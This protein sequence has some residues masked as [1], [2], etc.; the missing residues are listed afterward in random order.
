MRRVLALL[1]SLFLV[2]IASTAHA[3]GMGPM[4]ATPIA[5]DLTKVPVGTWAD[6]GMKIGQMEMKARWALVSRNAKG[7]TLETI[8]EGGMMAMMGGKMVTRL[9]LA[10]DPKAATQPLRQMVMQIGAKP[11]MEMPLDDPNMPAQVFQ[12]PDPKKLVGKEEITVA[13][14]KFKTSHYRDAAQRGTVDFWVAEEV[15]PLGIVKIVMTPAAGTP[16]PGGG[17]MPPIAMELTA[18]G[19]DA[20][21]V[22]TAKPVPYDPA[23]LGVPGAAPGAPAGKPTAP[24]APPKQK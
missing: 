15:A 18:R 7:Q 17:Q 6:Y 10:P 3:Q 20:K 21:P 24:P 19:K 12:R 11:P 4:P 5:T 1:A 22:I 13:G 16:G 8:I 23:L 9:V 2:P 14:G